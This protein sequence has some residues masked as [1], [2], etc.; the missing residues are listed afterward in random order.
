MWLRG[1][2]DMWDDPFFLI[3]DDRYN[4]TNKCVGSDDEK[5]LY[6]PTNSDET[7]TILDLQKFLHDSIS[8]AEILPT[9]KW[10]LQ[11]I[12]KFA[13]RQDFKDFQI[14]RYERLYGYANYGYR[15]LMT[16][17]Y[18]GA[19][20]LD[21][22]NF[23][24]L[25]DMGN[26]KLLGAYV[27]IPRDDTCEPETIVIYQ[28]PKIK[29]LCSYTFGDESS[30]DPQCNHDTKSLINLVFD[31]SNDTCKSKHPTGHNFKAE[32]SKNKK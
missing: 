14:Y 9:C 22:N 20:R 26:S 13:E 4:E 8:E 27:E 3:E 15:A 25:V 17:I 11:R 6:C 5:P 30:A 18:Q 16:W 10:S 2:R 7:P 23:D 29:K 24:E 19:Q 32:P 21:C 12:Q 31:L 28:F 1:G